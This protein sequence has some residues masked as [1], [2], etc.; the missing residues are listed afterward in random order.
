MM[1]TMEHEQNI[2]IGLTHDETSSIDH[3][4]LDFA[5]VRADFP[6]LQQQVNG[7]PLV[8]LDNA[9]TAQKPNCVIDA[10]QRH[11]ECDNANIHRGVHALSVRSTER[12][13][14]ARLKLQQFLGAERVEELIFVRSAT[15]AINLVAQTYARN[16]LST[17]D[18]VLI[19]ELEHHSN[20][21]PWQLVC[22]QTGAK[23]RI[24]PIND[25]GEV[26]Y[27]EFVNIL[28][29]KTKIAS[30]SHVSNALGTINPVREMTTAAHEAGAVVM[31]D[32]AQ[33]A[34]H[35][36]ID[37]QEI[38]CDFYAITG[39]KMFG[40]TGIGVLYGRYDLL[41][42]L[43]PYQTGGDMILSVSFDKTVYNEVPYKFEAGTPNISG[44][45][46]LGM[47]A[48]Y[49]MKLGMD[50][51]LAYENELLSYATSTLSNIPNIRII[52]TAAHKAAV[53]SF[54]VEGVH[55]HD[56]GTILD[57]AGIAVRTGHHCAQPVMAHF[58]IEA[59]ARASMAAYN[60]MKE[61]DSLAEAI[62]EVV[63]VFG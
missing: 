27:D 11:Y 6:I 54:I 19:T 56:V 48:D 45:I 5:S 30:F 50:R 23:L 60:T 8:Y 59:T 40:P 43:P 53:V 17:G 41:N 49:L 39:H 58:G 42:A 21:V 14:Q 15:E 22:E 26:I 63:E 1:N 51:V 35:I 32:G 7:H 55:A 3:T 62:R 44:A 31:I 37:V 20:I 10:I 36:P 61:I 2:G 57:N 47:A 4:G 12:Y 29:A 33:A 18:E 28:S 25:A 34:P 9:A 52:G 16:C 46:G 24:A 38:G 13:E